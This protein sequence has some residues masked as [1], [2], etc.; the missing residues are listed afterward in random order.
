MSC[1]ISLRIGD[2][3]QTPL[4]R[5]SD[6]NIALFIKGMIWVKEIYIEWVIENGLRLF[7]RDAVLFKIS[8]CL[9]LILLK[10]HRWQYNIGHFS[11]L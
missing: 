11:R 3:Q 1:I 9:F 8:C 5:L 6:D 7:K 10:F 2:K 4:P